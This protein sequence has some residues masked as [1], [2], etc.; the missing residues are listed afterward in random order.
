L[1]LDAIQQAP[2]ALVGRAVDVITPKAPSPYLRDDAR[3][4]ARVILRRY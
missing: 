2:S 1:H 3:T 4:V